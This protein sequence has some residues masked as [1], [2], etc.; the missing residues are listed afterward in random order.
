MRGLGPLAAVAVLVLAGSCGPRAEPG[1]AG[2]PD[3]PAA[4]HV[5]YLHGRI[6]EDQGRKA[7]SPEYGRYEYDAIL[8]ALG[9]AGAV[10]RSEV[11]P[12][13]T[14]P[15]AYA[16][17]VAGEVRGLL[18]G[19]VAPERITVVGASKGGLIAKLVS[20]AVPTP[21]VGYV[22]LGACGKGAQQA[23]RF[24]LHGD[25]LSIYEASD[26]IGRSCGP[27]FAAS[28]DLGRRD[29]IRLETGLRH[30]F[31]YRPLPEWVDPALEWAAH[32][33]LESTRS[34]PEEPAETAGGE[35]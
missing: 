34:D 27:L 20:T 29:E 24:D 18:D 15:V 31:L 19:G 17:Q 7:V 33:S 8:D 26:E 30:G 6:V 14:D 2:A 32:R 4:H 21:G 23:P 10:V 28:S 9:R 12:A 16:Q 35:S 5:F 13:G 3:A 11:R 22:L 25:V 1:E